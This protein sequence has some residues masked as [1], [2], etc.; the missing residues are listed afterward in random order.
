LNSSVEISTYV[1]YGPTH[2]SGNLL[3]AVNGFLVTLAQQCEHGF[4]SRFGRGCLPALC[5]VALWRF[6]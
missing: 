1:S 2:G 6:M 5:C 3:L 4:E